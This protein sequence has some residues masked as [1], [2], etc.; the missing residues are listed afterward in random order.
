MLVTGFGTPII[1][2]WLGYLPLFSTLFKKLRPYLVWPSL[3]GTY[4]VRPLPFLLGNAPPVGQALYIGMFLILN[5]VLTSVNY[6]SRQPNAWYANT[7]RE[8]MAYVMYRTGALA[9]IIAP[10]VWLFASRNN[11]LLWTT[12]WS[13]STFMVLHR[14]VA[15]IFT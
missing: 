4:Q 3:I 13:H 12:N 8:I 15:R 1:L 14:W 6:Q 5:I 11:F 7:W 9:Y 10:L 2:T